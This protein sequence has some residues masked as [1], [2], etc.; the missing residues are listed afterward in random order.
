MDKDNV[1]TVNTKS[2]GSILVICAHSDDQ[3]IGPG[4]TIA[5]YAKEGYDVYTIILS[6]GEFV[7]PHV[8]REIISKTR[9]KESQKADKIIGGKGVVFMGLKEN[10][11]EK[12]L[13][14][15]G[16]EKNFKNLIRKYKPVKIFTH[17][18]DDALNDH[19]ATYRMVL[20]T[21]KEMNLR[22]DLYTFD[23]W[24]L[25]NLKKRYR[26]KFVVDT[27]DTFKIKMKALRVFK[28]QIDLSTFYNYLVLNNFLF[29]LINIR[30][31]LKGISNNTKYAEVFHKVR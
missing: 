29:I 30:D 23:V 3:I 31:L 15:R 20:K 1:D 12:D 21:Y 10:K 6:F 28:S 8:K 17:A 24:H 25:F 18:P 7:Q 27:T 16:L 26:P 9:I 22:A 14:E 4:G 19:R 13:H 5:K 11:F 2:K